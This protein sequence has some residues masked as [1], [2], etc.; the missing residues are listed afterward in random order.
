[1]V[2]LLLGFTRTAYVSP[3]D[4]PIAPQRLHLAGI[5]YGTQYTFGASDGDKET[6]LAHHPEGR[7]A[8]ALRQVK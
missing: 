3:A 5:T 8:S 1:M 2:V 4:P 7:E 6:Q